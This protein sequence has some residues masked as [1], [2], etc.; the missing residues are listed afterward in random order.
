MF[1]ILSWHS[2][3][4]STALKSSLSLHVSYLDI[5]LGLS[6]GRVKS[7]VLNIETL[8]ESQCCQNLKTFKKHF[9]IFWHLYKQIESVYFSICSVSLWTID[10]AGQPQS[11][12][13]KWHKV[14][15]G[16]F[17]YWLCHQPAFCQFPKKNIILVI[18]V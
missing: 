16:C 1:R 8:I 14:V 10:I 15:L 11:S 18:V 3:E 5:G 12:C 2:E 13:L 17:I 9:E 7:F 4:I 6:I